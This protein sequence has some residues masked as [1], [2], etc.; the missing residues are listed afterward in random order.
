MG[1]YRTSVKSVL[2]TVGYAKQ[3]KFKLLILEKINKIFHF[4]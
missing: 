1:F 3:L 2:D 4:G